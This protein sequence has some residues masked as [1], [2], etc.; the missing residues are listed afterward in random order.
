MIELDPIHPYRIFYPA[1][2][3]A[4]KSRFELAVEDIRSHVSVAVL[5]QPGWLFRLGFWL[6]YAGR[7]AE[8]MEVLEPIE[9]VTAWGVYLQIPRLLGFALK[10]QRH[11]V[12]EVAT[13]KFR[14]AAKRDC[15][16]SCMVS[17][18]YAMLGDREEAL[19]WLETAVDHGF[20]N[21][22]YL[23]QNDPLLAKL[24]DEPRFKNLMDR[25]NYEW[26]HFEV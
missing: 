3:Q 11:R 8:A 25:V 14:E 1:V 9:K 16:V 2:V 15:V 19:Y 4:Y 20:I 6:V 17:G 12:D 23:S 7:V 10:A 22:P 5:E 21:Y 26:E 13:G 24:K 18:V